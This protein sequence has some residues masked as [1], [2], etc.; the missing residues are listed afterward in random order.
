ME[1]DLVFGFDFLPYYRR[2]LFNRIK[3][4]FMCFGGRVA[5]VINPE[6]TTVFSLFNVT[7]ND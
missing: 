5:R 3:D 2:S 6:V 4:I 7:V 1:F